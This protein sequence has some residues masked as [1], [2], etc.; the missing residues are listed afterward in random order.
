R[1]YHALSTG[2]A[3]L[4]AARAK[5]ETGRPV[6]LTEH[7]LYT[8][9]RRIE[10]AMADWLHDTSAPTLELG[11]RHNDLRNVWTNA[12]SAYARACYETCD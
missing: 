2:Y 5:I 3:G 12:F 10:L 8:N 9:E 1:V 11:K 6:M 7:G 4:V